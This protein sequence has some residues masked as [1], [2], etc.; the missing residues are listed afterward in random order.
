MYWPGVLAVALLEG[1]QSTCAI[2]LPFA[3][4]RIMETVEGLRLEGLA[5]ADDPRLW[6]ALG[7]PLLLFAALNFGVILV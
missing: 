2:L 1:G 7:D 3:I 6:A 5:G 4:R